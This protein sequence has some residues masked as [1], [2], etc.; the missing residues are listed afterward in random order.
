MINMPNIPNMP[1]IPNMLGRLVATTAMTL[2]AVVALPALSFP[3]AFAAEETPTPTPVAKLSARVERA[4]TRCDAAQLRPVLPR[5]V[6]MLVATRALAPSDGYYGADQ[7]LILFERLFDGRTTIG[8]RAISSDPK[9]RRDGRA[10]LQIRWIS[11]DSGESRS[12]ISLTLIL[13][14]EGTDWQIRE[15]RDLK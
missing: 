14:K 11:S 2:V 4:F 7:L 9:T 8:F 5:K 1:D 12:E 3:P 13:V 6:K 10:S 15:I